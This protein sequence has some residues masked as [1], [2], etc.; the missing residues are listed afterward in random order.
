MI[1]LIDT[2]PPKLEQSV[3]YFGNFGAKCYLLK[4]RCYKF[5]CAK[6]NGCQ[7]NLSFIFLAKCLFCVYHIIFYSIDVDQWLYQAKFGVLF[8]IMPYQQCLLFCSLFMLHLCILDR[9]ML[10]QFGGPI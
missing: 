6:L 9:S 2:P 4:I 3:N 8:L 10:T 1:K 5:S 7:C